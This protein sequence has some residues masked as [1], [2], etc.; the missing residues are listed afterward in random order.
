MEY[1]LELWVKITHPL[2]EG[3]FLRVFYQGNEKSQFYIKLSRVDDDIIKKSTN[4]RNV[5]LDKWLICSA[6]AD[7]QKLYLFMIFFLFRL[8]IWGQYNSI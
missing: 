4:L 8:D 6:R 5:I 2:S 1:I 7:F 3:A